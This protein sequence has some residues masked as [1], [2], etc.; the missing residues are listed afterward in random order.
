MSD[1]QS[2]IVRRCYVN[3]AISQLVKLQKSIQ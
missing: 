2:L 3:K 1:M